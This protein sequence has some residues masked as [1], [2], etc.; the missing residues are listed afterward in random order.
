MNKNKNKLGNTR[1]ATREPL[2]A[3]IRPRCMSPAH[4][5]ATNLDDA[6]A[7]NAMLLQIMEWLTEM[8]TVVTG[9]TQQ[10]SVL[11]YLL[12]QI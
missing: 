7:A 1:Q 10:A 2:A 12:H 9:R 4:A 8:E 3:R 5:T 11:I 6:L